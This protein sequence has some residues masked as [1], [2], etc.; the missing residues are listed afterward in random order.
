MSLLARLFALRENSDESKPFLQHLDELR[1]MLMRS[2]AVLFCFMVAS[3]AFR[4][5]LVQVL[6]QPL[7]DIDPDLPDKLITLSALDSITIS[8]SLAFYAGLALS[9]P[10]ILFFLL[11][12]ILPALKRQEKKVIFP[13]LAAG[14]VLFLAGVSFCYFVIWPQALQFLFNDTHSMGWNTAWTARDYMTLTPKIMV[15]FGLAFELPVVVIVLAYLRILNFEL[16]NRTRRY[17]IVLILFIAILIA[18]TPDPITF[19]SLGIPMC[20][21]Y[22]GCIWIVWLMEKRRKER[23]QA[24]ASDVVQ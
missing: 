19:L 2:V 8:F 17:A 15:G 11:Q 14:T 18:P 20:L 23:E 13:A 4:K 21:L 12:F 16:L 3:F 9:L 5:T 7:R 24:D 22:E 1:A 10:F 6:Q